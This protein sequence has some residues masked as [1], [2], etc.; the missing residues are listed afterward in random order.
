V[1]KDTTRPNQ[2]MKPRVP[3]AGNANNLAT[4]PVRRLFL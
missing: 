1:R 2:S 3:D 4:V